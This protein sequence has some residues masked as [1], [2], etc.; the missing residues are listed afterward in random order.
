MVPRQGS[1][2]HRSRQW[3]VVVSAVFAV[4]AITTEARANPPRPP[5]AGSPSAPDPTASDTPPPAAPNASAVPPAPAPHDRPTP[6]HDTE[7][8]RPPP[9]VPAPAAP[10]GPVVELTPARPHPRTVGV[11]FRMNLDFGGDDVMKIMT[12]SGADT[13]TAGGLVAFSGGVF[14]HPEAAWTLEATLGYKIQRLVYMI[15]SAEFTRFPMDV[16]VSLRNGDFRGGIG[17]TAHLAPTVSCNVPDACDRNVSLDVA[18]GLILQA[19]YG[20]HGRGSWGI[21]LGLRATL[22]TYSGANVKTLSGGP[23]E[24]DGSC[25]GVFIGGWL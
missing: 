1:G 13:I 10:G 6:P 23:D 19:A 3:F 21:D 16:I 17:T 15:G 2:A 4:V 14:F 8:P 25:A 7:Q 18:Y 5:P 11:L 9:P 20:F 24:L 12:S 22:I